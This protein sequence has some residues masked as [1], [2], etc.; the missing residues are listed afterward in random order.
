MITKEEYGLLKYYH[1]TGYRW[2]ARDENEE[3][4]VYE[5]KPI[6]LTCSW[7]NF[8]IRERFDTV[9]DDDHLF[10]YI[11]WDDEEPTKILDLI[12]DYEKHEKLKKKVVIQQFVADWIE[13]CKKSNLF[14]SSLNLLEGKAEVKNW[15]YEH[16]NG[17]DV[18]MKREEMVIKAYY[19]G[20]EVEKEKLYTVRLANGSC[21]YRYVSVGIDWIK[22]PSDYRNDK[23]FHL[24]QA[25]IESVDPIL[26]KIAE[27]VE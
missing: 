14:F 12:Q 23:D 27:E 6:K 7:L 1:T 11:K 20:Y 24:T 19:D 22:A 9:C 3:L 4:C 2:I 18:T 8:N 10:Q 17:D 13:E 26:M 15:I 25:E 5:T 21:L 16:D